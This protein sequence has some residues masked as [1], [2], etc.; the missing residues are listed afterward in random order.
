MQLADLRLPVRSSRALAK[1]DEF[2]GTVIR[3]RAPSDEVEL[4][5]LLVSP[6]GP[7]PANA[8]LTQLAAQFIEGCPK[9]CRRY[10]SG[11]TEKIGAR[12]LAGSTEILLRGGSAYPL[13]KVSS[14]KI[15]STSSSRLPTVRGLPSRLRNR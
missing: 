13:E 3:K 7:V 6:S 15:R 12:S 8:P 1:A 5:I 14:I 10:S 9:A 11:G 2:A 4:A